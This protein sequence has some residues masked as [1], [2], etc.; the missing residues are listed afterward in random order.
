M[1]CAPQTPHGR[2]RTRSTLAP[3]LYRLQALNKL[4]GTNVYE[5]N[6]Q[7]GGPEVMGG[8]G[9]SHLIVQTD[10]EAIHQIVGWLSFIPA[11][12]DAPLA[13][14]PIVDPVG[15]TVDVYPLS[16]TPYDPRD[17][18]CGI[19]QDGGKWTSGLLDKVH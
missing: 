2:P 16:G 7:L 3:A 1:P 12:V 19:E 6:S 9:V 14:L 17:L 5:S 8:N 11:T 13:C 10:L 4:L 15:R 18:L